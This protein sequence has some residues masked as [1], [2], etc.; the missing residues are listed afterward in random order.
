MVISSTSSEIDVFNIE[1]NNTKL[2]YLNDNRSSTDIDI[3]RS[4]FVN[5]DNLFEI[6][7]K[8]FD[9]INLY[10]SNFTRAT[11]N[12]F[13]GS[14][15]QISPNNLQINITNCDFYNILNHGEVPGLILCKEELWICL[16]FWTVCDARFNLPTST[17]RDVC[18]IFTK[19]EQK[20]Y[21]TGKICRIIDK[22][23]WCI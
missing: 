3:Y 11:F 1:T 20:T 2:L 21:V 5:S 14:N 23:F 12:I 9:R 15:D 16:G 10:D 19:N 4:S 8:R 18:H 22:C 17:T 7:I 6:F 13:S